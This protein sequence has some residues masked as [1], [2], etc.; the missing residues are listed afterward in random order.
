[1]QRAIQDI[2][3]RAPREILVSNTITNLVDMKVNAFNSM[4]GP[5]GAEPCP[6]CKGKGNIAFNRDGAFTMRECSCMT[7][8]RCLARIRRSG[9]GELYERYKLDTWTE[10]FPQCPD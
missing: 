6:E 9:L 2:I 8:R 4:P 7:R 10:S 1:M 5:A 3:S